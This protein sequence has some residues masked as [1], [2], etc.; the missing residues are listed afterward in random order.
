M[1]ALSLASARI[2]MLWIPFANYFWMEIY[3]KF[4]WCSNTTSDDNTN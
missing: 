3:S 2:S 1:S 4:L